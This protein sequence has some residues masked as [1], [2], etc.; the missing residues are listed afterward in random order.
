MEKH[1]QNQFFRT[2]AWTD[3]LLLAISAF[4]ISMWIMHVGR[5]MQEQR[6]GVPSRLSI[7]GQ[8][9]N[10]FIHQV[11]FLIDTLNHGKS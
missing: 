1:G 11:Y 5:A 10:N 9:P 2:S 7:P 6:S 3:I 4:T 8:P